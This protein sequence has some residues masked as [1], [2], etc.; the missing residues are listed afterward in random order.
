MRLEDDGPNKG[1]QLAYAS[2]HQLNWDATYTFSKLETTLSG[3]Y[4]SDAYSDEAN[5]V[6]EDSIGK[7]G[8]IPAY[9]V[10]NLNIGSDLYKDEQQTADESGC[11]QPV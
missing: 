1:N 11:Q 5:T 4:F 8:K 10:W 2:K 9:M 3:Y 6:E 7:A